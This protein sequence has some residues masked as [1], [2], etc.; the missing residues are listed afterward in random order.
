MLEPQWSLFNLI[1]RLQLTAM[2]PLLPTAAPL[3]PAFTGN[4]VLLF[5]KQ[6]ITTHLKASVLRIEWKP[7][8]GTFEALG[9]CICQASSSPSFMAGSL[10]PLPLW[11][12]LAASHVLQFCEHLFL[13]P[14]LQFLPCLVLNASSS[15]G[16]LLRYP[17]LQE[18][19]S[20][21]PSL[22]MENS[23]SR[24]PQTLSFQ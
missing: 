7:L 11:L 8:S 4:L 19:F 23:S 18:A 24:F 9:E 20:D 16:F 5:K 2:G 6:N 22:M 17:F 10:L 3:S 21:S 1:P 12:L 14:N 15:S 13:A